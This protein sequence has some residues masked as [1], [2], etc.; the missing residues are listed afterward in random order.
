MCYS[1]F[2]EDRCLKVFF[3]KLKFNDLL[4]LSILLNSHSS[5]EKNAKEVKEW[6]EFHINLN[7]TLKTAA[8]HWFSHTIFILAVSQIQHTRLQFNATKRLQGFSMRV[9][10]C[11][12][13]W[14]GGRVVSAPLPP[15]S[16][17][18]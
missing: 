17:I 10:R 12:A 9:V 15:V 5:S 11:V 13:A 7:F 6:W 3:F 4:N 14:D 1:R 16:A 2:V 8:A 18:R